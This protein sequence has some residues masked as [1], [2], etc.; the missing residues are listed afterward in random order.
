MKVEKYK[1]VGVRFVTFQSMDSFYSCFKK[2]LITKQN[3]L[4][5]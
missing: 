3:Y 5:L 1:Y 2:K 4:K